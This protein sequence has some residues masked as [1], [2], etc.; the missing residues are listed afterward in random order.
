M[1]DFFGGLNLEWSGKPLFSR[2]D[3]TSNV[4]SH[5]PLKESQSPGTGVV[6]QW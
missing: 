1:G 4:Q 6:A 5:F 3:F 2:S